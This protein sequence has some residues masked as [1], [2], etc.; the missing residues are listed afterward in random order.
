MY[1]N[2]SKR[3]KVVFR[4]VIASL[5]GFL[6]IL[7]IFY[8]STN[9]INHSKAVA[10]QNSALAVEK[11]NSWLAEKFSLVDSLAKEIQI[12]Q[13]YND[14]DSLQD[15]LIKQADGR[16]EI[17]TLG[18][19]TEEDKFANSLSWSPEPGYEPTLREWY[20]G[21]LETDGI[22][23]TLPY[24][25]AASGHMV[26]SIS[27]KVVND[28]KVIGV[29]LID[30]T[31]DVL[32]D[33]IAESNQDAETYLFVIDKNENIVIHPND[34]FNADINGT[35]HLSSTPGDYSEVL[36]NKENEVS[37]AI[38]SHGASVYSTYTSIPN[39]NWT[40]I[41]NYSKD[42]MYQN[43]VIQ[44]ILSTIVVF[45]SIIISGII[46]NLFNKRYISPLEKLV[47]TLN[48]IK[49]G[50]LNVSTSNIK[51]NSFEVNSL[52]EVTEDLS[53]NFKRY[54]M[55]ISSIL[56]SF[57]EGDFTVT[58]NQ[59]YQ[60]DFNAIKTSLINISN[61]LGNMTKEIT[62]SAKQV[63]IQAGDIS[64]SAIDLANITQDQSKLLESFK[65]NTIDITNKIKNDIQD[66]DRS[67]QIIQTMTEKAKDSNKLSDE[68]VN[69][70]CH[71]SNSTQEIATVINYIEEIAGQT[72]LLAL[73][74][75]IEAAR[76]GEAGKGFAI[77]ASE[78]RDLSGK[79]SEIVSQIHSIIKNNLHSVSQGEEIVK[80]TVKA[81]DEI[82]QSSQSTSEVSTII[83]DN[84][85][86]QRQSLEEIV[87]GTSQLAN[88]LSKNSA[89]S[90]ENVATS[91]ELAAQAT[92]LE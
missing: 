57:A 44:I 6:T 38:T 51:K 84:A 63:S 64:E 32:I 82:L 73:N 81:I 18:F 74:A 75:A 68:L 43:I 76:A 34:E 14:I 85:M 60:G 59:N 12:R 49:D 83:K 48:E 61:T 11:L 4:P 17:L 78:V 47:E 40:I 80:A 8:S 42:S 88:E 56:A 1:P 19:A 87:N 36:N 29:L 28:N 55:E 66:I 65:V 25:D 30:I 13:S 77:V 3:I 71:I 20:I 5:L 24:I 22:Y 70:M 23:L 91:Q 41:S 46:I 27:K 35:R 67:Y 7:Q 58:P 90:E 54:I 21:A 2:L 31:I 62:L 69:S 10:I 37:A 72:N 16:T 33:I 45:I 50:N 39:T 52:V 92:Q 15:Y 53:D 86:D 89:I 9:T 79:T 26:V